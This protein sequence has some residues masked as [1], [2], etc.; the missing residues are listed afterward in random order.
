MS[1]FEAGIGGPSMRSA[2]R[3]CVESLGESPAAIARRLGAEGV[4]G[5]PGKPNECA[6]ARYLQVVI[7]SERAV[8]TVEVFQRSLL[9]SRRHRLPILLRLP[10]PVVSFVRAFDSG[11]FPEL[12]EAQE[13]SCQGAGSVV[14][15]SALAAETD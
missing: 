14:P 2:V 13:V 3:H 4:R 9:V 8:T 10:Q 7:G 5:C 15:P 6:I 11:C 12:V 1:Y